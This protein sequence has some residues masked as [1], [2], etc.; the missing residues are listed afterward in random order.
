LHFDF[1]A[2][3]KIFPSKEEI[4]RKLTPDLSEKEALELALKMEL[5]A[6]N[7]FNKYADKF[8]DTKGRDIFLKFAEEENDHCEII[9]TT[10]RK[11]EM[12]AG[13]VR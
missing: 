6:Y 2:L 9:R 4:S 8:T 12:R 1:Q 13:N 3:K 5:D 10:L 11:L 7:F